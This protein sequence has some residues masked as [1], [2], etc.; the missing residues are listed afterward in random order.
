MRVVTP[1]V[2][3]V[4]DFVTVAAFALAPTLIPLN[5]LAA[6]VA[7]G[8]A[9]VHLAVTLATEFTGA[10]RKPLPLRGH[11]AL[12]AVVGITLLVLPF[13]AGW[14]G[15]PRI[16]YL[17]AGAVIL[18]VWALSSYRAAQSAAE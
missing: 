8:L 5:G 9:V 15:R 12:E 10:G 7:Y 13:V 14:I 18:I 6:A 3:K 11:G 4:L 1:K 2:H 16:F 17:A